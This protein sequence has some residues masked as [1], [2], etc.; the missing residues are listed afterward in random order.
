VALMNTELVDD[1]QLIFQLLRRDLDD[2]VQVAS[3]MD[4]D[5]I[6]DLPFVSFSLSGGEQDGN[7]PG[8]WRSSLTLNVFDKSQ[9]SAWETCR[10]LYRSVRTWEIPGESSIEGLGYVS[11]V[12]DMSKFS[13]IATVTLQGKNIVQYSG[14]FFLTIRS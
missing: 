10:E 8:L 2:S 9:D 5:S 7:G 3:E 6:E 11:S 13:R 12:T 4:V 1:E 14:M